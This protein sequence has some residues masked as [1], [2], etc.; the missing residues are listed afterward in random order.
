MIVGEHVDPTRTLFT[1]SRLGT[2]WAQ[3][4]VYE[5]DLPFVNNNSEVV[6]RSPL[7]PTID[8]PG[9]IVYMSDVL[10]ETL[11][12]IQVRVEVTNVDGLLKPN[13]Y[14]QGVVQ[15]RD[16]STIRDRGTG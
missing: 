2:L 10:D 15:N 3:L 1:V 16:G 8:F 13:M 4:D 11:R 6:I 7:H 5:N 9:K 12:T 14:I